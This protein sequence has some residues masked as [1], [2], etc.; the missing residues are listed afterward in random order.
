MVKSYAW[1]SRRDSISAFVFLHFFHHW[2]EKMN[3]TEFREV[4]CGE[5]GI[6]QTGLYLICINLLDQR[7]MWLCWRR[8][9]Y[10]ISGYNKHCLP[11]S[12]SF[13]N[14]IRKTYCQIGASCPVLSSPCYYLRYSFSSKLLWRWINTGIWSNLTFSF[15][16]KS[17]LL[18]LFSIEPHKKQSG[19]DGFQV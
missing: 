4:V 7:K 11:F 5:N 16:I 12:V 9:S 17:Q 14:N 6:L 13:K 10:N 1:L 2:L 3:E 15:T 18:L 19:F 8:R